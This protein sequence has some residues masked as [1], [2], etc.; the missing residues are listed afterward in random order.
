MG[1]G[2]MA[3]RAKADPIAYRLAL[4]SADARK[5]RAAL[6]LLREKSEAWRN[7][8]PRNHA[9]GVACTEYHATASACV[10]DVS[11]ENKR[12]RIHRV[13]VALHCGPAVN[14]LTVESQYQGGIVF[15][16]SQLMA[17]GCDHVE[18][19]SSGTT[20]L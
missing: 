17:K 1:G 3:V 19:R 2:E 18:G 13:T 9:A 4:L 8:L 5:L 7:S 12:P 16:V 11:I 14:P 10:V 15:G 20:K 6:T